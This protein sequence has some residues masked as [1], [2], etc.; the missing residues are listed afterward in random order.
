MTGSP[1]S[2]DAVFEPGPAVNQPGLGELRDATANRRWLKLRGLA[3]LRRDTLAGLSGAISNV[4][5]GMA[6]GVIVGVNPVHGLYAT[7]LGPAVGGLFSSTQ[8]MMISTTAAASLSTAQAL[9]GL[10]GE[11]RVSALLMVAILAGVF[12][13]VFGILK[14]GRLIRFVSYSVTTGFLSGISVLLILNQLP[15][16]TGYE[17]AGG[18][19]ISQTVDL[20]LNLNRISLVSL[21]V[22]ALTLT[23]AIVLPR[24]PVRSFGRL[25]AIA[26]PSALVALLSAGGVELVRDVG[27]IPGGLPLPVLPSPSDITLD[28]IT[29]WLSRSSFWCKARG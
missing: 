17:P 20:L 27:K 22:A 11:A 16:V 19:R 9:G 3:A 21:A 8:L 2:T 5:D 10:Q 29:G 18:N 1:V 15:V 4:P 23:L 12:Q 7:M 13:I 14:L 28:L 26:I 24:T 25:A 6:N